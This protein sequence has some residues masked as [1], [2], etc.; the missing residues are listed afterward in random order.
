MPTGFLLLSGSEDDLNQFEREVTDNERFRLSLGIRELT[1]ESWTGNSAIWVRPEPGARFEKS[2]LPLAGK[3]PVLTGKPGDGENQ[4][5]SQKHSSESAPGRNGEEPPPAANL[6]EPSQS[7]SEGSSVAGFQASASTPPYPYPVTHREGP[8][9]EEEGELSRLLEL[10]LAFVKAALRL[11]LAWINHEIA[12]ERTEEGKRPGELP[13]FD[14]CPPGAERP[15]QDGSGQTRPQ[16]PRTFRYFRLTT[17]PGV[18]VDET[19]KK[20]DQIANKAYDKCL[21]YPTLLVEKQ[22]A[23]KSAGGG[24]PQP[25]GAPMSIDAIPE[26]D[27]KIKDYLNQAYFSR[28]NLLAGGQTVDPGSTSPYRQALYFP[29]QEYSQGKGTVIVVIDT[30]PKVDPN[31]PSIDWSAVDVYLDLEPE[32]YTDK[33]RAGR[34]VPPPPVAL[35]FHGLMVANLCKLIA[36]QSR[37]VLVRALDRYGEGET[38]QII[39]FVTELVQRQISSEFGKVTQPWYKPGERLIFNLSLILDGTSPE[40]IDAPGMLEAVAN[41]NLFHALFVCAAGNAS[42]LGV[43][44]NPMEPAAYGYF[45]GYSADYSKMDKDEEGPVTTEQEP[46]LTPLGDDPYNLVIGVAATSETASYLYARYSHAGPIGAPATEIILDPGCVLK[47]QDVKRKADGTYEYDP[48]TGE[49]IP[50][51]LKQG[52]RMVPSMVNSRYVKWAGTSF[53]TPLVTGLA[54]LLLGDKGEGTSPNRVLQVKERIWQ[55]ARDPMW[56]N[57]PHEIDFAN[58]LEIEGQPASGVVVGVSST[59]PSVEG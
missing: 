49:H 55:T 35:E 34:N 15:R 19:L 4:G 9:R 6:A 50:I 37:V 45:G 11:V 41:A 16:G 28:I 22:T 3:A 5:Q 29:V 26:P 8:A 12:E 39:Q 46:R 1:P 51:F 13:L 33:R 18:S 20:I 44:R 40:T 32:N 7:E 14:P 54:A 36:P 23:L 24:G 31:D 58:A 47:L 48:V 10:F 57:R 25:I 43:A 2:L 52:G 42:S 30:A 56:W 59:T 27:L 38:S 53:A 17:L 21:R